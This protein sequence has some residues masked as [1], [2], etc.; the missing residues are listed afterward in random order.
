[1]K[2]NR[3]YRSMFLCSSIAAGQAIAAPNYQ[4][5]GSDLSNGHA[6]QSGSIFSGLV[7][8]ASISANQDLKPDYFATAPS[9]GFAIEYGNVDDIF[10]TFDQL[11]I[12]L[13]S[14]S[15]SSGGSGGGSGSE[16]SN[17]G[18]IAD[19]AEKILGDDVDFSKVA[20]DNPE[21]VSAIAGVAA[22]VA[23]LGSL[24]TLMA[25]EVYAKADAQ[26]DIPI[27]L[28]TDATG[29][30]WA[31]AINTSLTSKVFGLADAP[32][33]D[34]DV[35]LQNLETFLNAD[36]NS[37]IKSDPINLTGG[38]LLNVDP[39]TQA[40]SGSFKNESL[41][42][43]KVA[44]VDEFALNYGRQVWKQGSG[45][46]H[47]GA[48]LKYLRVGV[49][50]VGIRLGDVTDS[51]EIF[52]DLKNAEFEYKNGMAVDAG[53]VW[54]DSNYNLGVTLVNLNTPEFEFD[55]VEIDNFENQAIISQLKRQDT[56]EM[57]S[58]VK[59]SGGLFTQD[60]HWSMNVGLDTN[61]V[62]D[63]MR[64][65]S[66]WASIGGAYNSDL[67]SIPSARLGYRKNLV[68]TE[69]SYLSAGL[70]LFNFLNLDVASSLETVE[71]NGTTLPRS[72]AVNLGIAQSF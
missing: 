33:F 9:M 2:M 40:V 13:G 63:I 59:L 20:Q 58:Q 22:E 69:L 34:K 57:G 27:I 37:A 44:S 1:M 61:G 23:V 55:S 11:A 67:W 30:S 16:D 65:A 21:L 24:I 47:V 8:P 70:T 60:K 3:L 54:Q 5:A 35:A 32:L 68:G 46:L 14:S 25:E 56:Y 62:E 51:E 48:K 49:S 19:I 4:P 66:Q 43:T 6:M 52:N 28:G 64:D 39:I 50:Q 17:E 41:L 26:L 31:V 29:G 36:V 7:N 12:K 38:F 45:Q 42:I 10:D 15:N 71:I 53:V 72:F 18:S